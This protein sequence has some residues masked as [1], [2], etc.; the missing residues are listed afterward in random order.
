MDFIHNNNQHQR[1]LCSAYGLSVFLSHFLQLLNC[2][3]SRFHTFPTLFPHKKEDILVTFSIITQ[4][5]NFHTWNYCSRLINSINSKAISCGCQKERS[6]RMPTHTQSGRATASRT[7]C[8]CSVFMNESDKL[9]LYEHINSLNGRKCV[10][11]P[12]PAYHIIH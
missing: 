5:K 1:M 8:M 3:F 4:L 2:Y 12:P 10:R 6:K 11:S 9:E 7:Q